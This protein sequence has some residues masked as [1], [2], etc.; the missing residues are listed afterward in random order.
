MI[1]SARYN[2]LLS[3]CSTSRECTMAKP[4]TRKTAPKPRP[5]ADQVRVKAIWDELLEEQRQRGPRNT[6]R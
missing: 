3:A 5:S 4:R 2:I 1:L 6:G